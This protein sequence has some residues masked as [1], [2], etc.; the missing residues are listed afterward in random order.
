MHSFFHK[1]RVPDEEFLSYIRVLAHMLPLGLVF[2]ATFIFLISLVTDAILDKT[3][4]WFVVSRWLTLASIRL[5]VALIVMSIII[6]Q[7]L[8]VYVSVKLRNKP[9]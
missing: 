5:I 8:K 2:M 4:S 6:L 3:S 1:L 7:G 9:N